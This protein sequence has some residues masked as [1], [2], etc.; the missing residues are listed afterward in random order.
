M[1]PLPLHSGII[2]TR[3]PSKKLD[4]RRLGLYEVIESVGP[5]AARLRRPD[6][7]HL[8]PVFHVSLLEHAAGNPLPGQQS[9][10]PPEVIVDGEEEWEGERILDSRFYYHQLQYFVKW[11]GND[12]PSWQ[13]AEN[14]AHAGEFVRDLHRFYPDRPR[15]FALAGARALGGGYCHGE[16]MTGHSATL[17]VDR[18]QHL[19]P[20]GCGRGMDSVGGNEI[21]PKGDCP[22]VCENSARQTA[23]KDGEN[24][25]QGIAR[26]TMGIGIGM[27]EDGGRG[28]GSEGFFGVPLGRGGRQVGRR[29]F[30]Y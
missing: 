13:P 30:V 15:P 25:T 18:T 19:A 10:P 5:N 21:G 27:E 14:M 24:S 3:R 20:P 9:P 7:V 29:D 1:P 16:I 2:P 23:R 8:H 6:T 22:P 26:G 28:G 4:H 17:S 11:K 12:A